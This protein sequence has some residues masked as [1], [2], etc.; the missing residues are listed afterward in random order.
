MEHTMDVSLD[1]ILVVDDDPDNLKLVGGVL[2]GWGYT[3]RLLSEGGLAVRSALANPPDLVLLDIRLPDM[4]GYAVCAALKANVCTRDVPVIFCSALGATFD[5][6]RAF[7][8]GAV[9]FV[10]KPFDTEEVLAR[11]ATHLALRRMQR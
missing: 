5:K 6:V 10:S 9:D 1:S 4:D 3:V 2:S 8:A 11:V 7:A